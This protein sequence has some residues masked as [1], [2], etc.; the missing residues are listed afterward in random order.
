MSIQIAKDLSPNK[1]KTE[2]QSPSGNLI[3]SAQFQDIDLFLEH[4]QIQMQV[5]STQ[6]DAGPIRI[7]SQIIMMGDIAVI[8]YATSKTIF[9]RYSLPAGST[10]FAFTPPPGEQPCIWCGI[11]APPD[12]IGIIHPGREYS[13]YNPAGFDVVEVMVPDGWLVQ[14]EIMPT[15]TWLKTREPEQAIFPL[16]Q[17]R[18][19][20]FRN[21]LYRFFSSQSLIDSLCNNRELSLLFREWVLEELISVLTA[22]LQAPVNGRILKHKSR[23]DILQTAIEVV[24]KQLRQPLST[25]ALA[26][27]VGTSSRV[28]QY[29]FQDVLNTTPMRYILHR[30]LHA[31][32]SDLRR[33][34]SGTISQVS[35]IAMLYGMNHFGRFSTKYKQLFGE[36]PSSTLK[37]GNMGRL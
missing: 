2:D 36:S 13:N 37:Q 19:H 23:F 9:E 28:L 32:R 20:R 8:R 24:E 1:K 15:R 4:I 25:K 22:A 21:T 5:H 7:T 30:K 27:K 12:S 14:N 11:P 29:A 17:P 31:A 3:L 26:E 35:N 10:L 34:A 6:L 33:S 18:G 16:H